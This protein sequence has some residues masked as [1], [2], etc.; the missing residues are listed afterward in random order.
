MKEL[1]NN[2]I[3]K[4]FIR[5]LKSKQLKLTKQRLNILEI[6]LESDKHLTADEIYQKVR[7]KNPSTGHST[8]YRTLKLLVECKIAKEHDFGCGS[9]RYEACFEKAHHDHL[10][11]LK[12]NQIYEFENKEI[13]LLQ[14]KIAESFSFEILDHKLELYGICSSCKKKEKL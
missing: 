8:V 2:P 7:K 5:H 12:C 14:E 3:I 4:V 6:F 9:S 11:C 13:E 1:N 10:I